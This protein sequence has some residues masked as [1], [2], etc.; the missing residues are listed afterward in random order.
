MAKISVIL[1]SYNHSKY[2]K[3]AID[4]VLYQTFVNWELIIWDDGSSDGSWDIIKSYTDPRITAYRN[5]IN[6]RG[7]MINQALFSGK[8]S[9]EYVAI[10][11]SDDIWEPTKL[12]KQHDFLE[13]NPAVGAVF[14]NALIINEE[15]DPFIDEN[16]FYFN[17]F[18]QQNRSR[19][20][21][22]NYFFYH[23]NALCHPS[24]LIRMSCYQECGPYRYGLAQLGDFD[25][26]IRLC[27]KYEIYLMGEKLLR[28]RIR[29]N[30]ANT[31][32]NRIDSR[33]RS[34]LELEFVLRN[35]KNINADELMEIFPQLSKF[36]DRKDNLSNYLL[37]I[38]CLDQSAPIWARFLGLDILFELINDKH[39][40]EMIK[41]NYGFDFKEF[42]SLTAKYDIYNLENL[43]SLDQELKNLNRE[44]R[45]ERK[46]YDELL[47]SSSWRV[48]EPLRILARIFRK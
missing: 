25:M 1:T 9:G 10:H 6:K 35:Y 5:Q 15:G 13:K 3:E 44:L 27:L 16:H 2:L 19:Y 42:M 47:S 18:N 23:G 32:G 34:R 33:M 7:G 40:S 45:A 14:T 31:S 39:Y 22:L 30:E 36:K 38:V 12:E 20:E 17:I 21:W 28:F 37:S 11:H 4:S 26:W 24:V 43:Q 48:T 8:L 46:K 41:R 29:N